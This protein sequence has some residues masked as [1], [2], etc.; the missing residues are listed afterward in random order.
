MSTFGATAEKIGAVRHHP[1]ADRLDLATLDG[2]DFQ[3][4][5]GRGA[6]RQDDWVVYFPVDSL[7]P[8]GIITLLELTGKLAGK[9]HN[10]VKTI[11]LRGEYSQ[12]IVASL[13]DI[14]QLIPDF[15]FRHVEQGQDVSEVLG[16]TKYE[17]PEPLEKHARLVIMPPM[18]EV[19]DIEGVERNRAI[20][21]M[22][23]TTQVLITEKMEGSHYSIT[24][25]PQTDRI[26]VCQ[27]RHEILPVADGE[28]T[29]L[30]V[31]REQ[32]MEKKIRMLYNLFPDNGFGIKALTIRGEMLGPSIQGNIY[33]LESH[34]IAAFEIEIDGRPIAGTPF[35]YFA[36]EIGLE[37]VPVLATGFL[38]DIT[39]DIIAYADGYSA[40]KPTQLREGVVVRPLTAE[41]E[42]HRLPFH[43]VILKKRSN[44]YLSQSDL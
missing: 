36:N 16:V 15:D 1:N 18:V 27:R 35:L 22:L 39:T 2:I 13:S 19:Y 42:E 14:N 23:M 9:E 33:G 24:F 4:V 11:R 40:W 26:A 37:T 17:A 28:H 30:K 44:A 38:Q 5:V 31:T 7:L 34:R 29:W 41:I 32:E 12:G 20:V 25:Y 3:F 21:D 6:Y 8:I 10:R 43:R